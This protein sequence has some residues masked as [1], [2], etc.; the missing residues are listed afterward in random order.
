[1]SKYVKPAPPSPAM[2]EALQ[3]A[4]TKCVKSKEPAVLIQALKGKS[5]TIDKVTGEAGYV[6]SKS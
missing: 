1:M 6:P 4:L 3:Q 5:I 2:R